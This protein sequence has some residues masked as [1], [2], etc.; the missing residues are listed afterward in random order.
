[1]LVTL[2]KTQ[3]V[4]QIIVNIENTQELENKIQTS[5]I[6]KDSL[7]S[8]NILIVEDEVVNSDAIKNETI[9]NEN[10]VNSKIF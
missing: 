8:E 10:K 9:K 3:D 4:S 1:M 6:L 5:T 2:E 7:N